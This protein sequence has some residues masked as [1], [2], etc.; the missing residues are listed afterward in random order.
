MTRRLIL[1]LDDLGLCDG[2][3]RAFLELSAR[4]AITCGSVMVPA[5]CFGAIADAVRDTL[6]ETC[7]E[8]PALTEGN[9]ST[10]WV[11]LDYFSFVVHVFGKDCR[12]FYD[13]ERLWGNASR[14]EF[15]TEA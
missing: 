4:G 14:H 8:R 10:Q 1:H 11:L 9:E 15:P 12:A 5:P 3:N 13:L 7:G 6:R 2:A